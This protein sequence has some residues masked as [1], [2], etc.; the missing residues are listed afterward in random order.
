MKVT[1]LFYVNISD[2]VPTSFTIPTGHFIVYDTKV[3]TRW[4]V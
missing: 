1:T 4:A 3:L 2:Y